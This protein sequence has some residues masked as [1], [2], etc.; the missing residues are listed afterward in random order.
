MDEWMHTTSLIQ[1]VNCDHLA[2]PSCNAF[3]LSVSQKSKTTYTW[4]TCSHWL[5][6][7]VMSQLN[8]TYIDLTQAWFDTPTIN[9]HSFTISI[10]FPLP[11]SHKHSVKGMGL[12]K[13]PHVQSFSLPGLQK[14]FWIM[15]LVPFVQKWNGKLSLTLAPHFQPIN[16]SVSATYVKLRTFRCL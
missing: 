3:F 15:V 16:K 2:Y 7:T 8:C 9:S 10:G 6:C 14:W 11:F 13:V 4:Q 5:R 12:S 1:S